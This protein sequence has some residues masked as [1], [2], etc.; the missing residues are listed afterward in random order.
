VPGAPSSTR[1]LPELAPRQTASPAQRAAPE[2]A[3]R[4]V[5]VRDEQAVVVPR[6]PARP[7][8]R[9]LRAEDVPPLPPDAFEI[10]SILPTDT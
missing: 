7:E 9:V 10:L 2:V 5:P 4:A 3:T 1:Q 8:P 6:A